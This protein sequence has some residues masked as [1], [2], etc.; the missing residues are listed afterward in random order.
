MT[1]MIYNFD[2]TDRPALAEVGGKAQ[3]LI[4]TSKAGLP[5]PGGIALCVAFFAPWTETF[6]ATP[7]WTALLADPTKETCD[8]V[9]AL[10][11]QMPLT[12]DQRAT[13][14]RHLEALGDDAIFAV[15]SSS[16]EEDLAGSS[17]AGMYETF[18]GTTRDRLESVIAQ[19]YASMFD[20]RVMS[21]KTRQGIALEGAAISVIVQRQIASDVSGVGF[22]LNP[23]NNCYDEAVI[24]ASFGLGEAIVSGIDFATT[25]Q[26]V[27]VQAREG[28][29]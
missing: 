28:A 10:A 21:Y 4:A 6:K 1:T 29:R 7:E 17:F 19:A 14:D 16:P 15:R 26:E 12:Q 5:V 22:S 18:L 9:K 2:T 20:I 11:S 27:T 23:V 8:R 13:L 3:S 24:D 25:G